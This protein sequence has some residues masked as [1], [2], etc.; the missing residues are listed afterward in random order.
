MSAMFKWYV[1]TFLRTPLCKPAEG[2][3]RAPFFA[4]YS[5]MMYAA[6]KNLATSTHSGSVSM[7]RM[8]GISPTH[9]PLARDKAGVFLQ[10]REDRQDQHTVACEW[11]A[12]LREKHDGLWWSSMPS[13]KMCAGCEVKGTSRPDSWREARE[14]KSISEWKKE[15]AQMAQMDDAIASAPVALMKS[16]IQSRRHCLETVSKKKV[17]AMLTGDEPRSGIVEGGC[18]TGDVMLSKRRHFALDAPTRTLYF[19]WGR[20][21]IAASKF[22][23]LRHSPVLKV[24]CGRAFKI[25]AI[26]NECAVSYQSDNAMVTNT[27]QWRKKCEASTIHHCLVNYL[28]SRSRQK[29][30]SL[31]NIDLP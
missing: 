7:R 10:L 22:A 4:G 31:G 27:E 8:I 19:S 18:T 23:W 26:V 11:P 1:E 29:A 9:K 15:L 21:Y 12:T 30:E 17:S 20:L 25:S 24:R 2:Q 16:A 13:I 6:G 3:A 28:H 14:M 5:L